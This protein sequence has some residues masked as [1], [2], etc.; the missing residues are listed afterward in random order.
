MI[1]S[2]TAFGY[3][4]FALAAPVLARRSERN[5]TDAR[6][7]V[8][9]SM[10]LDEWCTASGIKRNDP[11]CHAMIRRLIDLRTAGTS[12]DQVRVDIFS[13][14]E[15][16]QEKHM[17]RF[18]LIDSENASIYPGHIIVVAGDKVRTTGRLAAKGQPDLCVEEPL[19]SAIHM[20]LLV[21]QRDALPIGVLD[22]RGFWPERLGQLVCWNP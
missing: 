5:S 18:D 19:E 2:V 3:K 15:Q 4:L 20:A 16:Q 10:L 12:L 17:I 13:S 1:L 8:A 21:R 6:D 22:V 11:T 7:H 14:Y 9:L